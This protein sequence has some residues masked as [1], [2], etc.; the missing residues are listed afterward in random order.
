MNRFIENMQKGFG[1]QIMNEFL[2][3]LFLIFVTIG[4]FA[5]MLAG[6]SFL[7]YSLS[8]LI[9][10][11]IDFFQKVISQIKKIRRRK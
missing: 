4:S 11:Y 3:N 7:I 5:G 8:E 10:F 2:I 9:K 1:G 6:F